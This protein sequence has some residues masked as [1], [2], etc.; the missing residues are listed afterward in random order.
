MKASISH[1]ERKLCWKPGARRLKFAAILFVLSASCSVPDDSGL[2]AD[3]RCAP[4]A[5]AREAGE[6]VMDK[7]DPDLLRLSQ[8]QAVGHES[9]GHESGATVR[10][11]LALRNAPDAADVARLESCGLS[12]GSAAGDV[13]TGTVPVSALSR[14]AQDPLVVKIEGSR[15]MEPEAP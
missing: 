8:E 2:G 6:A 11:M 13:L 4:V 3:A 12:M 5:A 9:V 14:L 7:L 15:P 10:V 1:G